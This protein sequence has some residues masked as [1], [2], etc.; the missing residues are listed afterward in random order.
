MI[1]AV[2][3]EGLKLAY[4]AARWLQGSRGIQLRTVVSFSQ[5]RCIDSMRAAECA[6]LQLPRV[7]HTTLESTWPKSQALVTWHTS[8]T[9]FL[10]VPYF[11]DQT[12]DQPNTSKHLSQQS[13]LHH[14]EAANSVATLLSLCHSGSGDHMVLVYRL[15]PGCLPAVPQHC[16][17]DAGRQGYNTAGGERGL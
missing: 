11:L 5:P 9:S 1:T 2:A 15:K 16:H 10:P 4:A 6:T 3:A 14:E 12:K 8:S 7:P 17:G 13:T